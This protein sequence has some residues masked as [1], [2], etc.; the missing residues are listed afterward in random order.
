MEK[1]WLLVNRW[2][3][4]QQLEVPYLSLQG[5]FCPL[6]P[7]WQPFQGHSFEGIK[8][9]WYHLDGICDW[10]PI[11]PLYKFLGFWWWVQRSFCVA[12]TQGKPRME[13]P[14]LLNLP[15]TIWS[16]QSLCGVSPCLL[17][18]GVSFSFHSGD[19]WVYKT[20]ITKLH[21]PVECF[22]SNIFIK[23]TQ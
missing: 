6:S 12:A 7:E 3:G 20:T 17:C 5:T 21:S 4:L 2:V 22:A 1:T 9:C 13:A 18:M 16:G 14:F 8:H 23:C 19:S 11:W 15:P 10:T